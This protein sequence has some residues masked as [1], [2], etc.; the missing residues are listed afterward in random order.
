MNNSMHRFLVPLGGTVALGGG[1]IFMFLLVRKRELIFRYM[2][3][4]YIVLIAAQLVRAF[5]FLLDSS[6]ITHGQNNSFVLS[7]CY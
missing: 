5:S 6:G 4:A 2:P 3:L 1:L 7:L